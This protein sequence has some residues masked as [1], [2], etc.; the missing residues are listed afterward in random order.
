VKEMSN[1][2]AK[3]NAFERTDAALIKRFGVKTLTRVIMGFAV[4]VGVGIFV[5]S[6]WFP[7]T[8]FS[9]IVAAG[10]L[11]IVVVAVVGFLM[12]RQKEKAN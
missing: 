4:V 1:T 7:L 12:I 3:R 11:F 8:T 2:E 5:S 9:P 6:V 10:G